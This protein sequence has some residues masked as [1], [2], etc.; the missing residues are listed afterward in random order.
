MHLTEQLRQS[1]LGDIGTLH[2]NS[3]RVCKIAQTLPVAGTRDDLENI[4]QRL[5]QLVLQYQEELSFC[6]RGG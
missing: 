5:A 4:D 3:E 2:E 6:G 1:M